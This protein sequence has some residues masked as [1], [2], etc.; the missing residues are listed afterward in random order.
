MKIKGLILDMDGTIADTEEFHRQ[1]FNQTFKEFNLDWHW[2]AEDYNK[3]LLISGGKERFKKCLNDDKKLKN[4]TNDHALFIQNLHK[5]KSIN[6]R[7]LLAESDINLRQ[8]VNRLINEAQSLNIKLG[9][10]TSSSQ[11]NLKTLLKKT[12]GVNPEDIFNAVITSDSVSEK[13]PSSVVYQ[14]AMLELGLSSN[15][16]V[17]IEDTSNGN[18]AAL[19]CGLKTI[20]TTTDYTFDNDFTGAS[21]VINGLGEPKEPFVVMQGNDYGKSYVDVELLNNIL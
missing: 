2:S 5:K 4:M 12:L 7:S 14:S 21:L 19:N 3:L 18:K 17:A 10:A 6:Y 8:G 16:C 11:D 1:A 13:K 20:I 15:V 9:V